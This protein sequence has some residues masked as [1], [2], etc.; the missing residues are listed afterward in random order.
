MRRDN[1]E[2]CGNPSIR[3]RREGRSPER[4]FVYRQTRGRA[5]LAV[6]A[7]A[8]LFCTSLLVLA[9]AGCAAVTGSTGGKNPGGPAA[10]SIS[11]VAAANVTSSAAQINWSTNVPGDS[12]V[13]YGGS[14]AYGSSTPIDSAMVTSHSA[15]LQGLTGS[16][17]IHFRV[18]SRDASGNLATSSDA[19]FTTKA[20]ADTTPPTIAISAPAPG[21]TVSGQ[22]SVS[23]SASDNVGVAS[24][25]FLLDGANL[26]SLVTAAPYTVSW[27]TA[28]AANGSHSL[29]A[30]ARDAA[31]NTTTS[32]A[33]SVTLNNAATDTTPPSVP[34]GLAAT[35]LSG[36][37]ISLSWSAS[38]DN[39]AVTGYRIFRNGTQAGSSTATAFTDGGLTP[40][41]NYS[42]TVAA[43]DAA[44]NA[45]A[46]SAPATATTPAASGRVIEIQPSNAD[47]SC[48][49][50]F[51]NV[52]NTLG[53]GDT[54][55][56]HGG[57]YTQTCRRLISGIHGTQANPITIM[58]AP[59]E[60]AV[61]T[62]PASSIQNNI[63]F[64]ANSYLVVHGLHFLGG[65]SGV[66]FMSGDHITFEDNEVSGTANNAIRANDSNI[67]SFVI[68]RNEVHHTGLDT[69]GPTEGE[70]MYLG[71][72][73]NTCRMTNSLILGNHIHHTRSTSSGGNDG[74]E[75][76]VGAA[77]NIVRDNVVHDTN[78]G[79]A[80]P[81]FTVY[82]GGTVPN[83]VERNVGWNCGEGMY[84]VADTI[85]RDN[86]IFNSA[87]GLS[88]YPHVQVAVMKN[89]IVEN[90]TFFNNTECLFLRWSGITS[91]VIANNAV[92]CPSGSAL[93]ASGLGGAT[94]RKNFV[95]GTMT[96]GS[97]DGTAFVNGGTAGAAF[98]DAANADFWP[99]AGGP[100][101]GAADGGFAAAKDF[102]GTVRGTPPDVGAYESAGLTANPGWRII[103]GFKPLTNP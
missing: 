15:S 10:I 58:A 70:G 22:V 12:Q 65:D 26:G 38:T 78:I 25:Q 4:E 18:K 31:G 97:I 91:G 48:N 74:I 67:D 34:T 7:Q 28:S 5:G 72:N 52:A 77:N 94:I 57:T 19:V 68:Q 6:E 53:P 89:V 90:N 40:G 87:T 80:F 84:I 83:I 1:L 21:A 50:E 47:A 101:R 73:N 9:M 54:L 88:S 8:G 51:E 41:T 93:N 81:C 37:Q 100:L 96:G 32:A 17:Q 59:G 45:S 64:D 46:Q 62:R 44:G 3:I 85:V 56:L 99:A 71:C 60:A 102:N 14:S 86:I 13:E 103:A 33:I 35:A 2:N 24:V 49:E 36:T 79:E 16:V 29:A 42:Y 43:F 20:A 66:R 27:N 30:T 23:A 55:I 75:I 69:S 82:G 98:V 76:K 63:E 39:V 92:Y 95:A 61:I 11:N